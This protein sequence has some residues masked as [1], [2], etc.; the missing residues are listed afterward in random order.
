MQSQDPHCI[1]THPIQSRKRERGLGLGGPRSNDPVRICILSIATQNQ[2]RRDL[3]LRC[4]RHEASLQETRCLLPIYTHTHTWEKTQGSNIH[5]HILD[6]PLAFLVFWV[7]LASW[8]L[9][10]AR[11][12]IPIYAHTWEGTPNQQGPSKPLYNIHPGH[13]LL[14]IPLYFGHP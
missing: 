2:T 12:L 1:N 4:N 11:H 8:A 13:F 6:I 7:L 14:G 10:R 3:E 9:Q 5:L